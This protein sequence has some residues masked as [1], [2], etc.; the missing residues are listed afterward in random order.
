MTDGHVSRVRVTDARSQMLTRR[1][2][3]KMLIAVVVM[4]GICFLPV[5]LLNILRLYHFAAQLTVLYAMVN[6][7]G[8]SPRLA[9]AT[10]NATRP[11]TKWTAKKHWAA[12]FRVSWRKIKTAAQDRARW[13]QMVCGLCSTPA[14]RHKSSK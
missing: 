4:F 9:S 13:R 10:V 7:A 3:A 14:A 11:Q 1:N 5:H 6:L 8:L 12:D 2:V